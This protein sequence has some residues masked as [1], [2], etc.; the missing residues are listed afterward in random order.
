[1]AFQVQPPDIEVPEGN[2]FQHDL[3]D[4]QQ[5]IDALT[6]VVTTLEGPCVLAVDSAWGTG[7][8][9]FLRMW[10]QHLLNNGFSVI[11]F[12]AWE[13]DFAGDPLLALSTELLDSLQSLDT[14]TMADPIRR[15]S[16]AIPGLLRAAAPSVIGHFTGG[17]LDINSLLEPTERV[18]QYREAI[19]TLR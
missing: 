5:S 8:T 3:L 6:S 12:N 19:R 18:A 4:R 2:P 10:K 7:K 15:L 14:P 1:M 9:T 13:T 16:D 17:V 11:S